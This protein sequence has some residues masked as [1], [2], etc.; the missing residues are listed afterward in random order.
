[1][2]SDRRPP[3]G[4]TGQP[5]LITIYWRDIP[6][7][8]VARAGQENARVSLGHRFQAAIDRAATRA[9]KTGEDDYLAEWREERSPCNGDLERVV[10]NA[11]DRIERQY[12][13]DVL[14]ARVRNEG[15]A[16]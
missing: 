11:M 4:N 10:N 15:W 8:V 2:V 13:N 7:Q 16:G 5:Q 3:R 6:A 14:D 12:P 1:V 9:G